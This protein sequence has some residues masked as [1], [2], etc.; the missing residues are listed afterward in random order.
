VGS[1]RK[2]DEC[3]CVVL[4][5]TTGSGTTGT[6][7]GEWRL[8]PHPTATSPNGQPI[9]STHVEIANGLGDNAS[10]N[11]LPV[12]AANAAGPQGLAYDPVNG[13]LY[14]SDDANNTIYAIPYA[15][16]TTAPTTPTVVA[17]GGA[18]NV[19]ESIAFDPTT[20]DLLVANASNNTLAAVNPMT[21]AI[22]WARV[23]AH[24]ATGAL[25][26]LAVVPHGPRAAIIY[27]DDDNTN[28]VYALPVPPAP[29]HPSA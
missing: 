12:T 20:G 24:G 6:G 17:T 8:T 16:T 2:R 25:F 7:G 29:H 19:P 4:L 22:L 27:Y 13:E 5:R 26:G 1:G 10:S 3:R 23:L 21:G 9:D 15:A 18:I 14:V 11:V 28:S